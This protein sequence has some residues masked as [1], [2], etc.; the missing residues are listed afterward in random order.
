MGVSCFW[1]APLFGILTLPPRRSDTGGAGG[2]S[3]VLPRPC[4]F[5]LSVAEG[6]WR[7]GPVQRLTDRRCTFSTTPTRL[8]AE[9]GVSKWTHFWKS[10]HVDEERWTMRAELGGGTHAHNMEMVQSS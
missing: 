2:A 8:L 5:L 1:L 3:S 10:P 6:G 4:F 9:P 7:G